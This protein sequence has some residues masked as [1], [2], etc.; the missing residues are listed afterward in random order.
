MPSAPAPVLVVM[1]TPRVAVPTWEEEPFPD[2]VSEHVVTHVTTYGIKQ[3]DRSRMEAAHLLVTDD[4]AVGVALLDEQRVSP[5]MSALERKQLL[6]DAQPLVGD[7]RNHC[8]CVHLP[9]RE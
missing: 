9:A 5:H 7:Q 3:I 6:G 2:S 4:S 1:E 8:R